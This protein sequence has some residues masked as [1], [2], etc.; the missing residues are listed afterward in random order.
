MLREGQEEMRRR[1]GSLVA[2]RRA[3]AAMEF[4][5]L[6]PVMA[7]MVVGVFNLAKIAVLWEQV[8]SAAQSIGESATTLA[9]PSTNGAQN[10]LSDANAG[11]ALSMVFA[12]IPWVAAGIATGN[13]T[14]TGQSPPNTMTVVLSSVDYYPVQPNCTT[15]CTYATNVIWSK[16]YTGGATGTGFNYSSNVLRTCGQ[17]LA[18]S[19]P[20]SNLNYG[21]AG[22]AVPDPF[23]IVD[24]SIVFRPWVFS[25]FTGP[26]TLSAT[27]YVPVRI[28]QVQNSAGDGYLNLTGSGADPVPSSLCNIFPQS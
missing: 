2:G 22:I 12:Q 28:S 15:N 4:G 10:N 7:L 24:V 3:V 18:P 11:I 19:S 14:G 26:F 21:S 9:I 20:V 16:A 6:A 5:I 17:P 27:S 25:V 23:V 13:Y 1:I 8:W